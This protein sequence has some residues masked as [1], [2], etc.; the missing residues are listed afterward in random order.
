MKIN[1]NTVYAHID[2]NI[3]IQEIQETQEDYN[4]KFNL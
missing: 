3:H 2:T 1:V 4:Y